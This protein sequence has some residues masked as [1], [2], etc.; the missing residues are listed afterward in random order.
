MINVHA[1][2]EAFLFFIF[3][4]LRHSFPCPHLITPR[5]DLLIWLGVKN[6]STITHFAVVVVA[7]QCNCVFWDTYIAIPVLF[8]LV[9]KVQ[10]KT[11]KRLKRTMIIIGKRNMRRFS[12]TDLYDICTCHLCFTFVDVFRF[13]NEIVEL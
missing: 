6:G 13:V 4:I 3:L 5:L 12:R 11:H 10:T 2:T 8:V 9:F 1:G 7:G